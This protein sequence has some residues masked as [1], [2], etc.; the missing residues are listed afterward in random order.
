M[1]YQRN[2]NEVCPKVNK[3]KNNDNHKKP[4]TLNGAILEA[5]NSYT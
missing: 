2:P 5:A 4:E 3:N 1:K